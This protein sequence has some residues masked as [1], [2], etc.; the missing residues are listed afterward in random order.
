MHANTNPERETGSMKNTLRVSNRDI[1]KNNDYN[2]A[3]GS[4]TKTNKIKRN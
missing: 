1:I 4:P 2:I 3:A